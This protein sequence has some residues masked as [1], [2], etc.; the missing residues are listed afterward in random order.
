MVL[1]NAERQARYKARLKELAARG[2]LSPA[3]IETLREA[4]LRR[5]MWKRSLVRLRSGDMRMF[6]NNVDTTAQQT[7]SVL[8]WIADIDRLLERFDPLNL[9]ID[10]NVELGD[11]ST[12]EAMQM[13]AG[14]FATYDT[15]K[16]GLAVNL[17][18]FQEESL[19]ATDAQAHHR[20]YGMVAEDMWSISPVYVVSESN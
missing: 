8:H 11:V 12:R 6:T 10:G 5:R 18:F 16:D 13:F 1:S 15:D 20:N 2:E 3:Q 9:T 14:W 17:R 19:A 7:E 4:R